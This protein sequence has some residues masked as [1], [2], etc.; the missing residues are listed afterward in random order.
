MYE[1]VDSYKVANGVCLKHYSIKYSS[2]SILSVHVYTLP[3]SYEV[4]K[5]HKTLV[6]IATPRETE[7]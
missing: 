2:C 1:I 4:D 3:H 7:T 6:K 5:V